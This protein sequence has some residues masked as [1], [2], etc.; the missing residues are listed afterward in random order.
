M[1]PGFG[2][3]ALPRK[4][5]PTCAPS[6]QESE[7]G[8][9][10]KSRWVPAS[11]PTGKHHP[12][13]IAAASVCLE[14][15]IAHV[16]GCLTA[17]CMRCLYLRNKS[18]WAFWRMFRK[19]FCSV[20]FSGHQP[21]CPEFGPPH[22]PGRANSHQMHGSFNRGVLADAAVRERQVGARLQCMPGIWTI[23]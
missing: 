23:R 14:D 10:V 12:A 19:C 13:P 5:P 4:L 9:Q 15:S 7:N 3:V 21:S 8:F 6:E 22:H 16:K 18:A 17:D 20:G 1:L 11:P 2:R